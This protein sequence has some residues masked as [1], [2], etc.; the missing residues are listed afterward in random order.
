MILDHSE[1]EVLLSP[2]G[3]GRILIESKLLDQKTVFSCTSSYSVELIKLILSVKGP[4]WL[5]DEIMRE[6]SPHYVQKALDSMLFSFL[7][8]ED[9]SGKRIL[10]FGCGSGASTAIMARVLPKTEIVGVELVQKLLDIANARISQ[11]S[12]G[13]RVKLLLSPS[14]DRLPED[15]GQFDFIVCSALVE[16]LLPSERRIILAKLWTLLKPGGV[17]LINQTPNRWSCVE[18]HSTSGFLF[19]NYVPDSLAY[20]ILRTFSRRNKGKSWEEMLRGGVRGSSV[21]EVMKLLKGVDAYPPRLLNPL[22]GKGRNDI[23][24]WYSSTSTLSKRSLRVKKWIRLSAYIF[25][26]LRKFIL[27]SIVVVVSKART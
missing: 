9:F 4:S 5:C 18:F 25:W 12:L 24:L 26:P 19:I 15:I 8:P 20:L 13:D 3:D 7:R 22:P 27:P 1:G 21:K 16:H 10:D 11:Q 14:P 23:N 17:L 6:E 2:N